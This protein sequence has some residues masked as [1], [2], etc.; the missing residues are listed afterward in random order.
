VHTTNSGQEKGH[1][2]SDVPFG[3]YKPGRKLVDTCD[4]WP[5]S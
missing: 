5:K 2:L 4:T 1:A 3:D